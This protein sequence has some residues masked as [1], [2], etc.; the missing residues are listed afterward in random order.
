MQTEHPQ[1]NGE[2]LFKEI[3]YGPGG[4]HAIISNEDCS[5]VGYWYGT[6]GECEAIDPAKVKLYPFDAGRG[7]GSYLDSAAGCAACGYHD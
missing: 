1:R 5:R 3:G 4:Y 7:R 2:K 6:P